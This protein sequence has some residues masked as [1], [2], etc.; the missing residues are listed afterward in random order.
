MR[1]LGSMPVVEDPNQLKRASE[2]LA[3]RTRG[4]GEV[5]DLVPDVFEAYA[6]IFHPAM[7]EAGP[8]LVDSSS[9]QMPRYEV[10]NE[11]AC[12]VRWDQVATA[13]GKVV[14]PG[15]QWAAI[16]SGRKAQPGLWD[17]PPMCDSMPRRQT[18]VLCEDLSTFTSVPDRCWCA[19]WEGYG[20]MVGLRSDSALPRLE[21]WNRPMIVA[22]GPLNA[23]PQ[24]AFNDGFEGQIRRDDNLQLDRYRS[25][26][27]WWPDDRTWCVA[28]DVEMDTTYLGA[29]AEC[30][31]KLLADGRLETMKV[32][33]E[34][35]VSLD[36]DSLNA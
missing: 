30:V 35:S 21:R 19:V 4:R 36:S 28:T 27:L 20:D 24:K 14:H 31:T 26:S 16:S 3:S 22:T 5:R 13:N 9:D 12:E 23:I 18:G 34:Q 33:A 6:R 29:S 15:M 25:P 1:F 2:W 11:A 17:R 32:T 7:R 10:P 8:Q